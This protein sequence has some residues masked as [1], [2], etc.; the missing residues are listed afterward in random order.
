M[1]VSL[2]F[3]CALVLW[4]ATAPAPAD[5]HA[6]LVAASPMRRAAL[7]EPPPYV[8]LAFS[9]RLEAAYVRLSVVDPTGLRVDLGDAAVT[10]DDARRLRVSL[11]PLR[12]GLYTVRFRVLSV[13]GHVVESSFPFT[14]R[15]ASAGR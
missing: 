15:D 2:A 13:D 3:L 12:P 10:P 9:E 4:V 8:E 11:P 14:V 7:T 6:A 5:G 1:S